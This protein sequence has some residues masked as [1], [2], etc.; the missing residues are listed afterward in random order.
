MKQLAYATLILALAAFLGAGCLPS[1]ARPP[2]TAKGPPQPTSPSQDAQP[3]YH[4]GQRDVSGPPTSL[5][6]PAPSHADPPPDSGTGRK[7]HAR[8]SGKSP[9]R[10]LDEALALCELSQEEWQKGELERAL[11][12]LD[13]SYALTLKVNADE[14]PELMQQKEDLRFMIAK[15]ILEIYASRQTVVTGNHNAIP[16]VLN[17]HVEQEL[18]LFTGKERDFFLRAYQRGG[19]YRPQIVE[20]LEAAGLPT[21]LSFLPLIESGYNVT[22]LSR[23]RALGLW[24]F[25]ASTGYK[26][27]LKRNRY[28]DERMDPEKS[29]AAAIEYLKELHDMFGDWTTV[30]AAYNCGEGR[31]LRVIQGQN[32]NYLD[33][34]W[35][36]YER[37]PLETARYVPRFLAALHIVKNPE[38]YGMDLPPCE[39]PIRYGTAQ[40][41]RQLRLKDVAARLGIGESELMN[42]NPELRRGVTPP[43]PYPLR[44][45]EDKLERLLADVEAIPEYVAAVASRPAAARDGYRYHR[46]LRGQ[47]LSSIARDYGVSTQQIVALN[48]IAR[49]NLIVTGTQI[50]IPSTSIRAKIPSPATKEKDAGKLFTHTVRAG[51]S[52]WNIARHYGTTV[53]R[54]QEA[55]QMRNTKLH[56]GQ[57]LKIPGQTRMART[58]AASY[59]VRPADTPYTISRNHRMPLQRFLMLN[60]LTK[61]STIYPGQSVLVE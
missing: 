55:N 58:S 6:S 31:V 30:L 20:S 26:F 56:I 19:R 46:V 13:R 3:P 48:N 21:E 17:R 15:R 47:T 1:Q 9:Q 7:E 37:L 44:V 43:E 36:L 29:T 52:L 59:I 60:G 54:I 45:P 61:D 11:D 27:G 14:D 2:I 4:P 23:A 35:D 18:A 8:T 34:F 12:A 57:I 28:V 10:L 24:Q 49:K 53:S 41:E 39:P 25:I 32:V 42:L 5:R 16:L 22:A 40:I 33:N 50:K 38:K 51:D